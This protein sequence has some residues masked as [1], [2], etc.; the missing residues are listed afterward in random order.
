MQRNGRCIITITIKTSK[1]NFHFKI[2]F[3]FINI[4]FNLKY[5]FY[6]YI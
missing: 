2:Y 5:L 4:V 6:Y 3:D 1:L